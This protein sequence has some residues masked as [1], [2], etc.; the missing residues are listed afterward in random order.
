MKTKNLF[1]ATLTLAFLC[2][3]SCKKE[4]ITLSS[5]ELWFPINADTS[6]VEITSN[7]DWTL[8]IDDDADW[9]T[10]SPLTNERDNQGF[11]TIA[12]QP[13]EDEEFRNSSFTI[14]STK[15]NASVTVK[16]TQKKEIIELSNYDLWFSKEAETKTIEVE[17][18]CKWTVSIDDG[19]DWYTVTPLSGVNHNNLTISVQSYEGSDFR[20]SSFTITSEHGLYTAKVYLSQNQLEFD[21]IINMVFGV[22][23]VE[24]WNT[25]YF[26]QVIEDSYRHKE[27]NPYDTTMGY[28][29]YFLEDGIG[30]QRD[31]HK[32]SVVYY[33]F[34]Y[35]YDVISRNLH[36]EFET[37]S[38]TV[39]D[40]DA[41]VLTAS[42]EQ[43]RFVHEYKPNWWERA[44]MHKIG[45][46][47]PGEKTLLL[48]TIKKRKGT[49][50]IFRF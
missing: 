39:E 47:N 20:N 23:K 31:H 46:I 34:T 22:S 33:A 4:T 3:V 44:E 5:Y 38:D 29:M 16:V 25:D 6:I 42:E 17:S 37:V 49:E 15:G 28:L 14:V 35:D 48:R 45:T 11:L 13:M 9:Y 36:I 18:N 2:L 43:F 32:D 8:R 27:Y 12:V 30:V 40:Y 21:E 1:L 10:V 24:Y 50:G 7:C 19:A 26:G 41:S